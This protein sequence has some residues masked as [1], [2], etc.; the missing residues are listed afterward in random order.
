[1]ITQSNPLEHARDLEL[2]LR[3]IVERGL[4][5]AAESCNLRYVVLVLSSAPEQSRPDKFEILLCEYI[6]FH[7]LQ[8]VDGITVYVL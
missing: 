3:I 5:F 8:L 6:P 1:M 2:P 7:T 4:M